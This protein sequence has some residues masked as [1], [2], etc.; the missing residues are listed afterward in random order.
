[1]LYTDGLVERRGEGLDDGIARLLAVAGGLVDA[2]PEAAVAGLVDGLL[3]SAGPSDDVALLVV[4]LVP[5]PL[6]VELPAV[7]R[8]M[9]RLRRVVEDWGTRA[10]LAGEALDDLHLVLGEA[11]ANAAEHA[12]P[13]GSGPVRCELA[14]EPDGAVRFAVRDAGRW[15]PVPEDNGHRGHGLRVMRQLTEGLRV[16]RGPDGTT[17]SGRLLPVAQ[18]FPPPRPR[19][20]DAAEAESPVAVEERRDGAGRTVLVLRGDLDLAGRDVAAAALERAGR[21]ALLDLTGLRYLSS[22]GVALLAGT[23][24]V[25]VRVAAGSAPARVLALTGLAAA[26]DVDVTGADVIGADATD[27]AVPAAV[28]AAGG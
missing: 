26:L 27:A 15:R 28:D 10:G 21:G 12:Y 14:R 20:A 17:V 1:V 23:E 22:A 4:R 7:A 2:G 3:T 18:A 25:A 16:D 6:E 5:E 19:P 9:A 24:D 8:S 11:A 13:D